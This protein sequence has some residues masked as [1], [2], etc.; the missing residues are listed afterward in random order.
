MA[1]LFVGDGISPRRH[2]GTYLTHPTSQ[3]PLALREGWLRV[4]SE[5]D[6]YVISKNDPGTRITCIVH[7]NNLHPKIAWG[8][9]MRG[10]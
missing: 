1:A 2:Y 6:V 5:I 3:V 9:L 7:N 4:P 10:Q 8:K